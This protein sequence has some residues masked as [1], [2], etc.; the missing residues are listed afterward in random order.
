MTDI[1]GYPSLRLG[2]RQLRQIIDLVPHMIFVKDENGRLL[3]VNEAKAAAHGMTVGELTGR[4]HGE[5]YPDPAA[6]ER[7]LADDREVL[8][9]GQAKFIPEEVFVD[10]HG[11]RLLLETIKI[12]YRIPGHDGPLVLG[13]ATDI[14][15]RRR[16]EQ[17]L[18]REER[19]HR[20]VLN[21]LDEGVALIGADGVVYSCNPGMERILGRSS[22]E[23]IGRR[24]PQSQIR[25]V[26]GDGTPF[27]EDQHPIARTLVTGQPFDNVVMG[28]AGP[29]EAVTWL[30]INT[31][32]KFREGESKPYAV[33]VSLRD[34]TEQKRVEAALRTSERK[35]RAL[36]ENASD[37]IA[38]A[39]LQGNYLD[40]N[41]RME[42]LL[43]YTKDELLEMQVPQIHPPDEWARVQ[44]AFREITE[45]GKSLYEHLVLRKD[46]STAP[47]E[48]AGTLIEFA[49]QQVA[50]GIFRDV[51]ER[52]Y[53]ERTMAKLSWALEQAADAIMIT[54]AQ[55]RIEYVN[56]GFEAA[57]GHSRDE[58][59][60]HTPRLLKSGHMRQGFYRRMWRRILGG[61]VLRCVFTNR[62]KDGTLFY[63]D[64]TIS[65]LWDEYGN[66]THFVSSAR[67]VT[68][69]T[70][71]E[72]E[73]LEREKAHRDLLVRE[74]HHRIKNHLQGLTGLLRQHSNRYPDIADPLQTVISQIHSVAMVHGLQGATGHG[75]ICLCDMTEAIC[76][77][78]GALR[79]VGRG[80][81]LDRLVQGPVQVA[82]EEAVPLALALNELIINGLK[83]GAAEPGG[84]P[85]QVAVG[86]GS[87]GVEVVV[88]NAGRSLPEGFD[89]NSRHGLGTGLGLVHALLPRKG[90]ELIFSQQGPWV[91][92]CLTLRPPLVSLGRDQS[93]SAST[94]N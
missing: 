5:L 2:E 6:V 59:L 67:D 44:G 19:R 58:V 39:D 33:V 28:L 91:Q 46:G 60:G 89:F 61:R 27:P 29:D 75:R 23:I 26:T 42:Q 81:R 72:Q 92:A 65:P 8:T 55:G 64:K 13:V 68:D 21:T 49:G 50:L 37:G 66:I 10:A 86:A 63:E 80:P 40:V 12:P 54:D 7:M 69:R 90:A 17:A 56:A 16:A 94:P 83:H 47:V 41:R 18:E 87:D 70:L 22:D 76:T 84:E 24:W 15:E 79:G 30:S 32:P 77:S 51:S 3:L 31:R 1:S 25:R 93:P 48:V 38:I 74:V 34:I 62:K 9:S 45:Q 20:E 11:N 4:C 71:A 73:R 57:T 85:V 35:Y 52:K 82:H 14:T 88:R 43:G 53:S 36:M 78:I